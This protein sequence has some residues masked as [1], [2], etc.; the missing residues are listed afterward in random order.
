MNVKVLDKKATNASNASLIKRGYA[1]VLQCGFGR[2][3]IPGEVRQSFLFEARNNYIGS[4]W[5]IL[6]RSL[7]S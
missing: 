3:R 2:I 6:R 7:R 1:V 5:S 4:I